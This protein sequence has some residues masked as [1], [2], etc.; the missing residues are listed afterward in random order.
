[1]TRRVTAL[2]DGRALWPDEPI[3]VDPNTR[4]KLTLTVAEKRTRHNRSKQGFL[5]TALSLRLDGPKDRSRRFEEHLY[6]E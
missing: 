3:D 5:E 2:F 4:V 6:G 1:M